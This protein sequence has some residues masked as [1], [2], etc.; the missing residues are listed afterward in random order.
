MYDEKYADYLQIKIDA[1]VIVWKFSCLAV[2]CIIYQ[3][4]NSINSF[5]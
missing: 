3:E 2:I 5:L 1:L 4:L